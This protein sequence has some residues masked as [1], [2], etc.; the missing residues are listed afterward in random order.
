M[1]IRRAIRRVVHASALAHRVCRARP[2]GAR[3]CRPVR[4][5]AG[6][7]PAR[8]RRASMRVADLPQVVDQRQAAHAHR[9]FAG[10][11]TALPAEACS[12]TSRMVPLAVGGRH[13][14]A[15]VAEVIARLWGGPETLIVDQFRPLALLPRLRRSAERSIARHGRPASWRLACNSPDH[16]Q[17][18]G[19]TADQRPARRGAANAEPDASTLH[20]PMRNSGDTAGDKSRVVG[21]ASFALYGGRPRSPDDLGPRPAGARAQRHRRPSFGVSRRRPEPDASSARPNPAPPSSP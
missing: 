1:A 11:A 7:H 9:T 13:G 19:A 21:Y 10:S 8:P 2:G 6:Q 18:C 17:A 15:E 5:A 20:R 12:A 3:R 14:A 4:H 16:E